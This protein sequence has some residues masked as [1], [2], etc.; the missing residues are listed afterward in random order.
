MGKKAFLHENGAKMRLNASEC[1]RNGGASAAHESRGL[2]TQWSSSSLRSSFSVDKWREA[3]HLFTPNKNSVLKK[4]RTREGEIQGYARK[5]RLYVLCCQSL[6]GA[7][8][9]YEN[10]L[11]WDTTANDA[12]FTIS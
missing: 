6:V 12:D 8:Q 4:Q 7:I 1:R 2:V 10:V 11:L 5:K 9:H 3:M